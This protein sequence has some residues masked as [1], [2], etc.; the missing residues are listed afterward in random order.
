VTVSVA[1]AVTPFDPLP[2]SSGMA[3]IETRNWRLELDR[4]V[5]IRA[6]VESMSLH[7]LVRFRMLVIVVDHDGLTDE[8]RRQECK[9]KRL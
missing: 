2:R 8:D 3:R 6:P 5:D 4:L 7:C 9:D 1:I